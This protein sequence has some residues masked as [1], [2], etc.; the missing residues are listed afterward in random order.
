MFRTDINHLLQSFDSHFFYRLMEA[1]SFMGTTYML[2]LTI[3]L[4][5]GGL[6]FRKGFLI[7]NI[8]GWGVLIMLG[9]KT[10]FDYPR[11]L[12]V[13]ST[14]ENF[15]RE[16]TKE[17]FR[18]LQPEGFFSIFSQELLIKSRASE[19]ARHGLPSGHV[20]IITAAWFGMAL[21]FRNKWLYIFSVALVVL[22]VVSRMYLGMHYL[23]D[24]SLGLIIGLSLLYFFVKLFSKTGLNDELKFNKVNVLFFGAPV[25][26][27]LLN[28][29]IP[30]FQGGALIGLNLGLIAILKLW[31]EPLLNPS[32]A[33]KLLN[34][35]LF[36]IFYFAM[37]FLSKNLG[38]AKAG[39]M[40][41][42]V[43]TGLNFAFLILVFYLGHLFGVYQ[44]V[45]P[46]ERKRKN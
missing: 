45:E 41:M 40:S 6:N 34:A 30:G 46:K 33:K 9:A 38:L 36:V 35:L 32:I 39:V 24:V 8:V 14:L 7:L 5:I 43:Y 16:Q 37:F 18:N 15:G 12:G 44:A 42:L 25:V 23:G 1:V 26:L 20:M 21:L 11:P 31:G 17:D 19:I 13:D 10:Y 28:K 22:T 27:L 4:L 29:A 2:L 3:L